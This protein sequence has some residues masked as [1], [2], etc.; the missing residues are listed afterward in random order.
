MKFVIMKW[1]GKGSK[2]G[3]IFGVLDE[4]VEKPVLP[5]ISP[6]GHWEEFRRID[7]RHFKFAVEAKY[8]NVENGYYLIGASITVT[9]AF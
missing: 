4:K 8:S 3:T 7:E 5:M 1:V 9:E 2:S 6:Q